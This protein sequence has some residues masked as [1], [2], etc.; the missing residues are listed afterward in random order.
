MRRPCCGHSSKW[1]NLK[2]VKNSP[3]AR[4]T[5]RYTPLLAVL[6]SPI[7]LHPLA[8]KLII[9][10]SSLLTSYLL[11]SPTLSPSFLPHFIWSLNPFVLNI[12]TRGSAE[13]TLV[14]LLVL[15]LV[16]FK[17]GNQ[18]LAA[19]VWGVSVHW[20]IYPIVYGAAFLAMLHHTDGGRWIS[21]R[22]VRF[23]LVSG[24]TFMFLGVGCWAM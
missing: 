19:I 8:G 16:L 13:S 5:Y 11:S 20:K 15:S 9:T 17:R 4:S 10:L 1:R 6:F 22:K 2:V 12:N 18:V 21:W 3:Y 14:V 23:T 7:Q 24:G